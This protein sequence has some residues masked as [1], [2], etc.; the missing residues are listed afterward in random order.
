MTMTDPIA[1]MLTRLRNANQAYHESTSMPYSKIKQGIA[2]I[3]QQEGYISS[4]KVEE[5]KEGA[6]GKTLIVDLKFGPSR[7]RSI[8]GVRRISKPGLRVYAKSTNLPKVLGGLGV[9]IISTSQGLLTDRQAKNK[10]VGGEVLA[11]VW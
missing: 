2:D 6:V 7:E 1:D 5:P 8:A 10:G 3:L 4:Y 11:Y 9:A